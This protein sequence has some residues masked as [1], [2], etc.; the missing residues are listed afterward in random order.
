MIATYYRINLSFKEA[1]E[2]PFGFLHYL[3][4]KAVQKS[5]APE[6]VKKKQQQEVEDTMRGDA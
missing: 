1:L 6:E 5:Q 4:Y 2:L 3:Y